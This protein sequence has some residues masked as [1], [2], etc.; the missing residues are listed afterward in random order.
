M[1]V[2][3]H[4]ALW[5]AGGLAVGALGAAWRLRLPYGGL[6]KSLRVVIFG[7]GGPFPIVPDK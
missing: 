4:T 3:M 1:D 7:G 2:F 5:S 6:A